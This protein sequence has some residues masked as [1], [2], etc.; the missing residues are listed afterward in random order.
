MKPSG[1]RAHSGRVDQLIGVVRDKNK[2]SQPGMDRD[3]AVW[4]LI[5]SG[6]PKGLAAVI[7]VL[8]DTDDDFGIR[9]H[10]A[11]YL[12]H[13]TIDRAFPLLLQVVT[14]KNDNVW[15]RINAT[16]AL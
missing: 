13:R 16:S 14:N 6:D 7:D 8:Q 11:N 15:V 1:N 5:E 9:I 3:R 10:I 12:G 2:S 4:S